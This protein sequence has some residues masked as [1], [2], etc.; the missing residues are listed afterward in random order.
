MALSG[1]GSFNANDFHLMYTSAIA[2]HVQSAQVFW[3]IVGRPGRRVG[4]ASQRLAA[5][6]ASFFDEPDAKPRQAGRNARAYKAF[7]AAS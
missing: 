1:S 3:F 5:S 2:L 4:F 6:H 7:I